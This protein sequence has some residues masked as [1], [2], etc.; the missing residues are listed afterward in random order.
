M[1]KTI[2]SLILTF[3]TILTTTTAQYAWKPTA[4]LPAIGR[5]HSAVFAIGDYLYLLTGASSDHQQQYKDMWRYDIA[6]N[7]WKQLKDF[8]GEARSYSAAFA[9]NGKGYFGLGFNFKEKADSNF[10]DWW[11]Y[12][13]E[14][15]SWAPKATFPG[16][17][18]GHPAF[19][20]L[21][22]EGYI[23]CGDGATGDYKDFYK[24]NPINNVWTRVADFGGVA[25]HHPAFFTIDT[26]AYVCT[27]HDREVQ[28]MLNTNYQYN[29]TTDKWTKKADLPAI[30]R[31]GS[32]GFAINGTGF[33]GCGFDEVSTG[34]FYNDFYAYNPI[35]DSWTTMPNFPDS[36]GSFAAISAVV[37]NTAYA[38]TGLNVKNISNSYWFTFKLGSSSVIAD[39]SDNSQQ[40][41]ITPSPVNDILSMQWDGNYDTFELRNAIG[42][43]VY[44][45]SVAGQ[46]VLRLS[47]SGLAPG[48]YSARLTGSTST[49]MSMVVIAR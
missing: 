43:L 27:G 3:L 46:S 13:P 47:T 48:V 28:V 20:V 11:E 4:S 6:A 17:G 8:P 12:T 5:H 44:S 1:K 22:N 39:N 24:Y 16:E 32:I 15:D 38:G 23:G 41:S 2:L 42:Q 45:Q 10:T 21:K 7:S 14:T 36:N 25:N 33:I 34:E 26:L 29:P 37:G 30:G 9:I 18:R 19:F 40:I 49:V 31:V 35:S